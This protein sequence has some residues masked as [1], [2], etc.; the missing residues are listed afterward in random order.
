[1]NLPSSATL[2]NLQGEEKQTLLRELIANIAPHSDQWRRDA[3]Q[4][5]R[6]LLARALDLDAD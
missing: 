6:H 1:L 5:M 3:I 2:G 4:E